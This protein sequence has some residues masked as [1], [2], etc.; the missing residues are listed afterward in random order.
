VH[1]FTSLYAV[2][3]YNAR[4]HSCAHAEIEDTETQLTIVYLVCEIK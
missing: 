2:K 1:V 4:T 3:G